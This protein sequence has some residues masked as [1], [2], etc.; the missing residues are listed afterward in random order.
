MCLVVI[1]WQQHQ[2]YPLVLAGNRDEFHSRPTQAAHWWP[3]HPDILAGRDLEAGGTWLA[4]HRDGRF[5]TITNFRDAQHEPAKFRSRGHL[6]TEFLLSDASPVDYLESIDGDRYAGF[7]LIVG[8]NESLAYSSNRDQGVRELGPGIY[9]LSNA[10][11]DS[12]WFKVHRA[13][14]ALRQLLDK[15]SINETEL[16]RL[17]D[18]RERAPAA[19]IE[20]SRFDFETAHAISAP[21]IVLPDYGTR[22]SSTMIRDNMGRTRFLERRFDS[23]GSETGRSDFKA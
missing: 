5:A 1:A 8:D 18:D 10:L 20:S 3:D 22:S 13:K 14:S 7:N 19:G 12:D 4:M 16:L 11:L 2:V 6:L 9:G 17:L 15:D 21:F 23:A